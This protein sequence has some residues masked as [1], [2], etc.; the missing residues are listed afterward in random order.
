[1]LRNVLC[2]LD[3]SP[4]SLEALDYAIAL[5]RWQGARLHLLEVVEP[6]GS[7]RRGDG[8]KHSGALTGVRAALE[9]DLRQVLVS[10]RAWDVKV[11]ILMREGNVVREILAQA[12]DSRADLVV[13]GSHGRSGVQRL[14]LGSV[15]EKVLRRAT[16]PVLTVR[17]GVSRVRRHRSPF[18]TILCPTDLSAAGNTAVAYA[19]RLARESHAHL[20]LMTAVEWP[21]GAAVRFGPIAEIQEQ[22][23]ESARKELRRLLPRPTGDRPAKALVV[24]GK[25]SA[26]IVKLARAGSVDLIVMG[27]SGSDAQDVRVLGSTTHR[28][29]RQGAWPVLTVPPGPR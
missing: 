23:E 15:A 3:R 5:A 17:R 9:R 20:T 14:V 18:R 19:K 4:S 11:E 8:A 27:L 1:M 29:I 16:C 7:P 24:Q 10:R 2:P 22:L 26:A 6:V 12:G 13:M 21:A 25:A 28:V